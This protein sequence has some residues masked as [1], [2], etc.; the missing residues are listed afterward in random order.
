MAESFEF[1]FGD[2]ERSKRFYP[3]CPIANDAVGKECVHAIKD[4]DLRTCCIDPTNSSII[5]L[6]DIP[7]SEFPPDR[8]PLKIVLHD[9]RE[10][11]R[12]STG[13]Q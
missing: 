10:W 11:Y 6:T 13:A 5:S 8:V 1:I 2:V 3:F 4:N 12:V 7:V 9:K